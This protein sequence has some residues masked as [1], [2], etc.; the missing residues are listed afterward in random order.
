MRST[1]GVNQRYLTQ[2]R[3]C[4]AVNCLFY[5]SCYRLPHS[6]SYIFY[7]RKREK[8]AYKLSQSISCTITGFISTQT[9]SMAYNEYYLVEKCV[10]IVKLELESII[11]KQ[12]NRMRRNGRWSIKTH[13]FSYCV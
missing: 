7:I 5:N 12:L 8:F 13:N 3:Q 9:H 4:S 6:V 1:T 10:F 2:Y 11:P